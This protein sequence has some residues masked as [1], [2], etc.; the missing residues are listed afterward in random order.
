MVA[1]C[2]A[3]VGCVGVKSPPSSLAL[4][5]HGQKTAQKFLFECA[6]QCLLGQASSLV[7]DVCPLF[8]SGCCCCDTSS[9]FDFVMG[10]AG[11]G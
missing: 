2:V 8:A 10:S 6:V 4:D 1:A 9:K 3:G 7:M 11:Q 5:A